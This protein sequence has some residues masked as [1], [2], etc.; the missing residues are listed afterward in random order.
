MDKIRLTH[1]GLGRW[2]FDWARDILPGHPDVEVV[3]Y[4]DSDE[5]AL[6]RV[7]E[8][9]GASPGICFAET[10]AAL[11][12]VAS[13]GVVICLPIAL[14]APVAREALQ[15][16][17]HVVVEK[18]F[19]ATL[20]EAHELA[21]LAEARRRVLMVSQNYRYFPA[22]VMAAEFV[23]QGHF[24]KLS[25]IKIDFRRNAPVEGHNYWALRN[26]LLVD[27]AVHH[28][29]LTRMIVGEDPVE[30][31]CRSWNPP[32]SPFTGDPCG[33]IVLTFPNG[34][35]VSYRGSWLD[36]GPQTA[37]AGEWQM[38]FER[39]SVL[40]TSRADRPNSLARERFATKRPNAETKVQT[41]PRMPLHGRKGVLAAF[42]TVI[43][44]GREPP[45]FPS[46]RSNI[47]TLAIIE[48]ALKSSAAT[49]ASQ[50]LADVLAATSKA[51]VRR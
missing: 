14:H 2:G 3:A 34:V 49:G 1:I 21:D 30:L 22:P 25:Q 46:G 33:A 29:D 5:A 27:M 26:P 28:Y 4:V 11:R 24:G 19:T 38:D 7:Q 41:L 44:T 15:A 35:A 20:Q 16:G 43:R 32:G 40:W 9:L 45:D 51:G 12:S 37:W 13:D 17:R 6:G 48:A 8:E 47:A 39:G 10:R 31:S 42:A 18:P 23:R 50:C 36:Q